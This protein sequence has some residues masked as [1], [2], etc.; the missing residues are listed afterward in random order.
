M[1]DIEGQQCIQNEGIIHKRAGTLERAEQGIAEWVDMNI[2]KNLDQKG[3]RPVIVDYKGEGG[4]CN[5]WAVR[6]NT[7]EGN[8]CW[9]TWM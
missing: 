4:A 3:P 8:W 5:L 7:V 2:W 9:M 1:E 6:G